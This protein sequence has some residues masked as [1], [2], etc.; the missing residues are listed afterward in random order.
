[1]WRLLSTRVPLYMVFN[2]WT[3]WGVRVVL[4]D[5]GTTERSIYVS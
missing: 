4:N 1:M 3:F 2:A 5:R